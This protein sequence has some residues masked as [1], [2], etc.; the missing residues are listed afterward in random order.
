MTSSSDSGG[1]LRRRLLRMRLTRL[2][3]SA[4]REAAAALY[5]YFQDPENN[6]PRRSRTPRW[7]WTKKERSNF[8]D[9][10]QSFFGSKCCTCGCDIT[11]DDFDIEHLGRGWAFRVRNG[12]KPSKGNFRKWLAASCRH[13][14][15][16]KRT[17]YTGLKACIERTFRVTCKPIPFSL[18]VNDSLEKGEDSGWCMGCIPIV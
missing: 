11:V 3:R 7:S 16:V 15:R 14:N 17:Q 12:V 5:N 18:R 9:L 1:R 4:K 2:P 8:F 10:W 13:C 6:G